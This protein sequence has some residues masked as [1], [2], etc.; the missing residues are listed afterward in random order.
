MFP[1]GRIGRVFLVPGSDAERGQV[2]ARLARDD[3]LEEV[4]GA[5]GSRWW[6][7]GSAS[8]STRLLRH[9]PPGDGRPPGR[10]QWLARGPQRPR[11]RPRSRAWCRSAP[12]SERKPFGP[13]HLRIEPRGRLELPMPRTYVRSDIRGCR[14]ELP[15]LRISRNRHVARARRSREAGVGPS[16]DAWRS[17]STPSRSFTRTPR[18]GRR[19]VP[20]SGRGTC[21]RRSSRPTNS[22]SMSSVSVNLTGR[23]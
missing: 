3:D 7:T 16:R 19:S 15:G 2:R 10:H 1:R 18:P 12:E 17:V 11:C 22:A 4:D 5:C 13:G 21:W 23:T 6:T 9:G 14:F 8:T 20:S